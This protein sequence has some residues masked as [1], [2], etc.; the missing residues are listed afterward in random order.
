MPYINPHELETEM[1]GYEPPESPMTKKSKGRKPKSEFDK[2]NR[3]SPLFDPRQ[4]M[5]V[6]EVSQSKIHNHRL[7]V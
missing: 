5:P 4:G 2:K 7:A 6:T 1:L 3:L